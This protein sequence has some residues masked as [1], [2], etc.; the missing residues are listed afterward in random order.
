MDEIVD[1]LSRDIKNIVK[2]YISENQDNLSEIRLRI[3]SPLYLKTA[4]KGLFPDKSY[5]ITRKDIDETLSG[6]T[7]NSIHA[8]EKE[9]QMGYITVEGGH[10]VGLGGDCV[11]DREGLKGFRNITSMNIRIA[12]AYSGCSDK[13]M[14]FFIKEGK[15]LN[16]LIAGPPMSGKT[17]IIRD[18]AISLSD[19]SC[20]HDGCDVTVIDERGEITASYRG[21]PQMYVGLRSDVL[22][23]CMKKDGFMMSIRS[24]APSVIVSDELGSADDFEIIQYALKSGVRVVSTA[25]GSSLDDLR[26]NLYLKPIIDGRFFDRIAVL[27]GEGR[28]ST[29]DKIYDTTDGRIIYDGGD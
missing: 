5:K 18:M 24:L 16:V 10:R 12:R 29:V 21:V 27:K 20:Q 13:Y 23:Y 1:M 8:F 22:S 15:P 28:P 9:I 11:Y 3:N 25:H 4:V 7:H 19:G 17:T 2:K 26:R 6:I 14:K